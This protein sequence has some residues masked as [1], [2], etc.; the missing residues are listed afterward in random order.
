MMYFKNVGDV[1][2][3]HPPKKNQPRNEQKTWRNG[4][5]LKW[6]GILRQDI[7]VFKKL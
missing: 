3:P 1:E 5:T 6:G 2:G 4:E 7:P